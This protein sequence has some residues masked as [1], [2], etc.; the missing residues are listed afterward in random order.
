MSKTKDERSGKR[1]ERTDSGVGC[2]KKNKTRKK[3]G[4]ELPYRNEKDM[5]SNC[6]NGRAKNE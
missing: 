6:R 4:R 1:F 5:N 2:S 3:G